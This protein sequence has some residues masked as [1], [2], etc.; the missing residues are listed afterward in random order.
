MII[1]Q[2]EDAR[3]RREYIESNKLAKVIW[4]YDHGDTVC[5]QYHPKGIKGMPPEI[6]MNMLFDSPT[7]VNRRNDARNRFPCSHL[8]QSYTTQNPLFT[9]ACMR[10]KSQAIHP[11][12]GTCF[13]PLTGRLYSP[14]RARRCWTRGGRQAMGGGVRSGKKSRSPRFYQCPTGLHERARGT[15]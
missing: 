1:M 4:G 5:V 6:K 3:K 9:M 12:N 15:A 7:N 11:R 2:T 10:L 14:P 13:A 8:R